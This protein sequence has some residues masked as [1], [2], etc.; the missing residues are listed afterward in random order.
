MRCANCVPQFTH[1]KFVKVG[2]D[3]VC[4]LPHRPR[5]LHHLFTEPTAAQKRAIHARPANMAPNARA[6][7]EPCRPHRWH[8]HC[9]RTGRWTSMFS[10]WE[11]GRNQNPHR[12]R[13]C[14]RQYPAFAARRATAPNPPRPTD[15]ADGGRTCAQ[16]WARPAPPLAPTAPSK[17]QHQWNRSVCGLPRHAPFYVGE[18]RAGRAFVGN[19]AMAC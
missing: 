18:R 3:R 5:A 13:S 16:R 4:A 11:T 15:L 6:Q 7:V 12:T 2:A 17:I 9:V 8:R 1:P 19:A 14:A 10:D